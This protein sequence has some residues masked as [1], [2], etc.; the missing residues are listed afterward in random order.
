MIKLLLGVFIWSFAHFIPA[1]AVGLRTK[2]V[3]KLGEKPYK[4]IFALLMALALYLIISGWKAAIPEILYLP[5][6]WG[7]HATSLLV[8][9]GFILFLAPYPGTNLK[10]FLRH[11]QLIGVVCW[12]VGHLL[13]NGENR[14]IVL[15]GGLAA[16]AIIEMWLLNRRDGE[17]IKPEPVA[18]K[19]DIILIVAGLLV[20]A[21]FAV[22]HLWLFGFSP[23]V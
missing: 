2:L 3:A 9:V 11:P 5:P 18:R 10:R 15:F 21:V 8:L 19:K 17:W 13:A 6:Q 4:G 1:A 20:Y 12:G 16:W 7:R 22:S 23:F 14:S